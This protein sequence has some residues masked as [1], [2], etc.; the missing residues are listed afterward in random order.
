MNQE[1]AETSTDR[2]ACLGVETIQFAGRILRSHAEKAAVRMYDYRDGLVPVL[3]RMQTRRQ[4]TL[5]G[6]GFTTRGPRDR[7]LAGRSTGGMA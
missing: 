4:R 2:M 3:A 6:V 1:I 5:E 7:P